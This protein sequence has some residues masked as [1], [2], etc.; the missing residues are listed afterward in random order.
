MKRRISSGQSLATPLIEY[1]H[2]RDEIINLLLA[3]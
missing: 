3:P 1:N 2:E